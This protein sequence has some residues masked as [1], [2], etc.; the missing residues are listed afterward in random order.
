MELYFTFPSVKEVSITGKVPPRY[1]RYRIRGSKKTC[2]Q[3]SFGTILSQKFKGKDYCIQNHHFFLKERLLIIPMIKKPLLTINYVLRGNA[4]AELKGFGRIAFTEG[5]YQF[6]YVPSLQRHEAVFN[7]GSYHALHI[8]FKP[9][10]FRTL[11]REY[12]LLQDFLHRFGQNAR[13]G[14]AEEPVRINKTVRDALDDMQRPYQ[15]THAQTDLYYQVKMAELLLEY[16]GTLFLPAQHH[17]GTPLT[18]EELFGEIK[19]YIEANLAKPLTISLLTQQFGISKNKLY[20][21]FK[22]HRKHTVHQ[23]IRKSRLKEA[24]CLLN[25]KNGRL[26]IRTIAVMVGYSNAE[27]LRY[28]FKKEYG[29]PP[30]FIFDTKNRAARKLK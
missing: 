7:P 10:Y 5:Y 29:I 28:A 11:A 9:G 25:I 26:K 24:M 13:K 20:R 22:K 2:Y 19:R 27:S 6:F 21:L 18:D 1:H 12:P 3:G 17:G 15:G 30:S 14:L 4:R 8:N 23:F 16:T